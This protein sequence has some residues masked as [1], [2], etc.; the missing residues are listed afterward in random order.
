MIEG[1]VVGTVIDNVDPEGM[2]R[3][4]VEYP[5]QGDAIETTWCRLMTPMAGAGRG[6]VILPDIGTE[7][8]LFF[9]YRSLTPYVLGG[10]YNG[11]ED[12]DPYA[13]ADG[14]D[15]LR[16]L[17]SRNDHMVTFDDTPGAE[18]LG[19]GACATAMGDVTS[20]P[21][22]QHLDAANKTWSEYSEQDIT[23]EAKGTV[24]I[25]C[26]SFS[27]KASSSVSTDAGM[28]AAYVTGQ[29]CQVSAGTAI[30]TQ[31]EVRTDLNGGTPGQASPTL[32]TPPHAHPP[33]S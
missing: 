33:T 20:A 11:A 9:A 28:N 17:W 25:K 18:S 27:L 3:I 8:L 19:I 24:S 13:N 14:D 29:Q 7:V 4:K 22:H 31:A 10:V 26:K 16:L 12:P 2:H 5:V 6:L 21:V 23:W 15:N 30:I 1:T 32:P